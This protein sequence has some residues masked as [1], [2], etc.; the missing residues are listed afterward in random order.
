MTGEAFGIILGVSCT[1]MCMYLCNYICYSNKSARNS[2]INNELQVL[3]TK[4]QYETMKQNYL[5]SLPK[6]ARDADEEDITINPPPPDYTSVANVQD[7]P[8]L[9]SSTTDSL[10]IMNQPYR[11]GFQTYNSI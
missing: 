1:Y 10:P 9:T 8:P 4:D 3:I 7:Y 11:S 5:A 6:N 2:T